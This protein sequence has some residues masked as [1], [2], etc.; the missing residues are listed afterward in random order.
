MMMIQFDCFGTE[1]Q[2][3]YWDKFHFVEQQQ[4]TAVL[5]TLFE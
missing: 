4:V 3:M 2:K 5:E 1:I